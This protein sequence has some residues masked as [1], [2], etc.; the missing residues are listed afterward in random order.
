[1]FQSYLMCMRGLG[2][3]NAETLTH[4][5][6]IQDSGCT[7]RIYL[8]LGFAAMWQNLLGS[9]HDPANTNNATS[10]LL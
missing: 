8:V 5:E 6:V 10:S 1:M 9:N 3:R 4:A 7:L 2:S